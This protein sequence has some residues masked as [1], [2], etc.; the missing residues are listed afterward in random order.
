[1][2]V[3]HSGGEIDQNEI[4]SLLNDYLTHPESLIFVAIEQHQIVGF[5]AGQLSQIESPLRPTYTIGSLDHWYVDEAHRKGGIGQALL[6]RIEKGFVDFGVKQVMVE[7]WAFNQ[8][9]LRHYQK[10][11]YRAHIHCLQKR[12]I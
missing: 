7:V 8:D 10:K 5:V 2:H 9:A 11:G 3:Q 6:A 1:M 4:E 12:L